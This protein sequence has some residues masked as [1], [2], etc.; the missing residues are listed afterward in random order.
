MPFPYVTQTLFEL[1]TDYSAADF[2]LTAAEW[3][4]VV[5]SILEEESARVEGEAYADGDWRTDTDVP[6][7]VRSAVIALAQNSLSQIKER[8]LDSESLGSGASGS[9]GSYEFTPQEELREA[10]K[11]DLRDAGFGQHKTAGV[12]ALG[13]Y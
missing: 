9:G 11:Q 3:Q 1:R 13:R 4:Q 5:D 12:E 6:P 7:A 8:G 10:I 2:G